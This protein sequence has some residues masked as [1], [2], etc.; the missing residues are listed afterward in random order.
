MTYVRINEQKMT[1]ILDGKEL[2]KEIREELRVKISYLEAPLKLAIV[3]VGNLEESN[4]YIKH[5]KK[6]A[7]KIGAEVLH[8]QFEEITEEELIEEIKKLNTD[9][10]VDGII[11]Q[12]P[13]PEGFNKEKII[14]VIDSQKD[15][16]GLTSRNVK[17]IEENKPC[18]VPATA[19]GVFTLLSKYKIPISGK[20]ITVIG[21]SN[22]VGKPIAKILENHGGIIT[23]G[24]KG[25]KDLI[26]LTKDADILITATGV[27]GLITEKHVNSNQTVIDVG[28]SISTEGIL[29]GD[30]D[31]E[32]VKDK[33][34]YITPVPGGVGPMTI[35]SLFLNLLDARELKT[36][37]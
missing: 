5:K 28:T 9:Q 16:D 31:F 24:H 29:V 30:V 13:L 37:L 34:A 20:K 10:S 33:V 36:L 11:V 25:T 18:I 4:R 2:N 19:R 22:L 32:K 7:E 3:Q 26:P 14:E 27:A 1:I 8:S 23:V 35:A 17:A 21:R 12:L 6:F 15:V